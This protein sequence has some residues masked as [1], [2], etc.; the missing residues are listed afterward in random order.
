[1]ADPPLCDIVIPIWNQ[2]DLTQ[3]CVESV[4]RN[5]P[6]P[7]RLILIDNGS[8]PPTQEVLSRLRAEGRVPVSL[9]R[10]ERNLGFIRATNQGIRACTA[11]WAT[12]K[13]WSPQN[14][15]WTSNRA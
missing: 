13:R 9:I 6:G 12:M 1:M 11:P 4:L 8:E 2:M 3:R 5:T 10:N 14:P 15:C 7:I